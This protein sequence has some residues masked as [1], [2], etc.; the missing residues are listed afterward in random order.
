MKNINLIKQY[1]GIALILIGLLG[2]CL[3]ALYSLGVRLGNDFIVFGTLQGG[4][5]NS[6]FLFGILAFSG[7][8]LLTS[9]KE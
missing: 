8:W 6:P 4:A 5:S 9:I 2:G 7:A 1:A 3:A